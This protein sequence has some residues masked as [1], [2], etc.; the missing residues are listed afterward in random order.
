MNRGP[1][2]IFCVDNRRTNG[3]FRAEYI[4]KTLLTV[5]KQRPFG[6]MN[7]IRQQNQ[8]TVNTQRLQI[9]TARN[10]AQLLLPPN[11]NELEIAIRT[12]CSR[13]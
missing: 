12:T 11:P 13:A 5:A 7:F 4:I 3:P 6:E 2:I 8:A 9:H 1:G 10:T